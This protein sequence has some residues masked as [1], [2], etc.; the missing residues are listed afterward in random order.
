LNNTFLKISLPDV[1]QTVTDGTHDSPKIL[2][3]GIP[4][5]KGKH[6]SNGK[7]DFENCDFISEDDHIKCI[8]RI[9]PQIDDV[10]FA[11][12][13]SVG[14]IARVS[15]DI[16]FSIKNVAL[17]RP[18]PEIVNPLYFYYL[19]KSPLF[20]DNIL[21]LKV[22]AAQPFITL[23]MFR[24]FKFYYDSNKVRQKRIA[25]ILKGYDDLIDNN[26]RRIELLEKSAELLYKEWFVNFRF[27]GYE[28]VDIKNGV[29][30]QWENRK[31][32]E[33]CKLVGGGTPSTK[34]P[35]YWENGNIIWITPTDITKNDCL[36]LLDSEKKITELGLKNSSAKLVPPETILMTSRASIGFFAIIDKE[37]CTN[38]GFISVI[39]NES[40][41]R[42]YILFNL[43]YRKEEI[44]A[45]AG[46]TTYKE[47][48]KST[49]RR[50][51]IILPSNNVLK[52]FND[53][54]YDLLKQIRNLKK[55][56]K[57]LTQAR[58]LL[59]P[60]LINGEIEV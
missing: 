27:P 49:F 14:D 50:M 34:N 38:Q 28:K 11:N 9:K 7:I 37:A 20:R 52:L 35:E 46:G 26:L 51:T 15:K 18:N 59:L 4:F 36:I 60:K 44:I 8:K 22:G 6:I 23:E 57:L 3:Y 19:I 25:L 53:L 2:D 56:N 58:D 17:F 32:E 10:L 40:C 33:I 47:I 54:A 13:G 42:M 29:P 41:F 5:I 24:G 45:H 16:N 21:K 31:I 30:N 43:I 55:Q 39:P 48:I 1:C 12:I